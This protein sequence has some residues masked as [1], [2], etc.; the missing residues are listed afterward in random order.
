MDKFFIVGCPRSGTTMVQQALNRHSRIVIPP[1]TKFFFSFLGQSRRSQARHID[2][3]NNDLG[4]NLPVPE[5]R[6]AGVD[7]GRR[8]YQTMARQYVERLG[9]RKVSCFGE[10]TPEHTGR[11]PLIRQL[12]PK[13]K[14]IV[15]CRDGRDVAASLARVPWM[16]S[17]VS[18]NFLVWL[19]YFQVI[20]QEREQAG[21]NLLF[22]RYEDIVAQPERELRR[23]VHF[24]ELP[25]EPAVAQGCGNL[26]GIPRREYAW[27]ERALQKISRDRV[28]AFRDEL[29]DHQIALIERLG[30]HAL[31]ALGYEL[32]TDGNS[33]F[34]PGFFLSL[35]YN[36]ARLA[37]RLPWRALVKELVC[38]LFS[39]RSIDRVRSAALLDHPPSASGRP[40]LEALR[41]SRALS[42]SWA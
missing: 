25:Y 36:A 39:G 32:L 17:D 18:V 24:L 12:F 6:V 11:L 10:K 13:A 31:P 14:I 35:A 34:P 7:E 5:R 23:M 37:Y 20:Q 41:G 42:E 4:I 27:K 15:L 26:E 28:G 9:K 33:P 22:A 19:Y 2:R 30:R 16:S 8:F 3:L 21:S 38:R 29:S 1:E 40:R